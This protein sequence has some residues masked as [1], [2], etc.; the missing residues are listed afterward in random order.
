MEHSLESAPVEEVVIEAKIPLQTMGPLHSPGGA[1]DAPPSS[2]KT[3]VVVSL[4][5]D[6]GA[7]GPSLTDAERDEE[8]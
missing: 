2:S 5:P 8:L 1:A 7:P 4:L 6:I 3:L